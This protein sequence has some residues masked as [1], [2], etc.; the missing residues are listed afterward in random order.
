MRTNV[1]SH[2]RYLSFFGTMFRRLKQFFCFRRRRRCLKQNFFASDTEL[3][4]Q[5]INIVHADGRY[6][7]HA[8]NNAVEPIRTSRSYYLEYSTRVEAKHIHLFEMF[9]KNCISYMR[10]DISETYPSSSPLAHTTVR[11]STI[12]LILRCYYYSNA[13]LLLL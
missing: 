13:P 9:S 5:M 11:Y 1:R 2:V 10:E 7:T 12:W 3:W 6:V 8:S 4:K